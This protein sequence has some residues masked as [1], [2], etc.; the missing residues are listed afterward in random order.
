MQIHRYLSAILGLIILSACSHQSS[1]PAASAVVMDAS[2]IQLCNACHDVNGV[3]AGPEFPNIAG[4]YESYLLKAV[5]RYKQ[6]QRDSETMQLIASLHSEEE[7][8]KFARYYAAQKFVPSPPNTSPDPALWEKGRKLYTQERVYGISCE[9]CHG[10][11]GKGFQW[12]T[13]RMKAPRAVPRLA[14]QQHAYL[15]AAVQKYVEGEELHGMCTMRRAGKTLS[16]SDA[17]ALVEYL[18]SL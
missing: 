14:G 3:S 17:K 9:D 10:S 4:Q 18:S 11:D 12:Q 13:P 16:K 1:K 6:G 2:R 15:A 5:H 7:M 8:N